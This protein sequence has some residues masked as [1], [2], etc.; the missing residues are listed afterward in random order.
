MIAPFAERLQKSRDR[1][2]YRHRNQVVSKPLVAFNS[3]DYLGLAGDPV[4]AEA[5][6]HGARRYGA[7][8]GGSHLISGHHREHQALEEELADFVGRDRALLFSS[9]YMANLGVMQALMGRHDTVVSDRLNH[10][11]LIDAAKLSGAK[12]KRYRHADVASARHLFKSI[13]GD[14]GLLVTD[15]I[16]S[17]DGDVAPLV[18]LAD[19]AN[20]QHSL[21]MVDD[22]H[23]FGLYGDTGGGSLQAAGLSQQQVPILMA[24]LSKAAGGLGA[25]VAGSDALIETLIQFARTYVYTTAMPAAMA[26]ALRASLKLIRDG[27]W[28]R[29]RLTHNI[30]RFRVAAEQAGL[31]LL[32][33]MTAIQGVIAGDNQTALAWGHQL[34]TAGFDVT[35]IRAPTVPAGT[36][37]LRITLSS[38]HTDEQVDQLIDALAALPSIGAETV[39]AC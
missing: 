5:L 11:S 28:R 19:L 36:E 38:V 33:S 4:V 6:A 10:A 25:F 13:A 31:P 37:R 9:G 23:G 18:Q 29:D 7:G 22:A 12:H 35:P 16:F 30:N 27:D 17:M 1:G 21:M 34:R 39:H 14:R 2:L 24:T 8:S 20:Q 26:V 32:A 15:C 3:N